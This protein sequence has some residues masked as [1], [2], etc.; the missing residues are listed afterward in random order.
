MATGREGEGEGVLTPAMSKKRGTK[1][2]AEVADLDQEDHLKPTPAKLHERE[3]VPESDSSN[4]QETSDKKAASLQGT[5]ASSSESVN[6]QYCL[7]SEEAGIQPA[8]ANLHSASLQGTRASP[9]EP[10][11]LQYCLVSEEAEIQPALAKLRQR[12]EE[13]PFL[14]VDCE[15][16]W[17]S[18]RGKLSIV[19]VATHSH[20]YLFDIKALGAKVFDEGLK[21]LLEDPGREKLMFDCREDSDCLWHLYKVRLAKV[22]DLQ[23]LEFIRSGQ[24]PSARTHINGYR[25]CLAKYVG[26][27]NLTRIKDEGASLMGEGGTEWM[28]R[29]LKEK[30][31][32]YAA[33]DVQG[34]FLLYDKLKSTLNRAGAKT[35]LQLGSQRY[36]DL[37]RGK[38]YR[39]YDR[40]ELNSYL[41][42]GVLDH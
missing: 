3:H 37:F 15:G 39:T 11:K 31:L 28:K 40:S 23:L 42:R 21:E 27:M 34:F 14:A 16:E 26:D 19:S 1:R 9:S 32:K 20:T 29:P 35:R 4:T 18:R 22:V 38:L 30:L 5:G 13:Y 24:T 41:P 8:L 33:L 17:L 10:G 25:K 12:S 2:P 6:L 7:V 36:L